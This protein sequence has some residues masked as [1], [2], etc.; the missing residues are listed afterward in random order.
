M[1][2]TYLIVVTLENTAVGSFAVS[3][4]IVILEHE[5]LEDKPDEE[6]YDWEFRGLACFSLLPWYFLPCFVIVSFL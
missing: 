4:M 3:L 5:E 6:P 1:M 2:N